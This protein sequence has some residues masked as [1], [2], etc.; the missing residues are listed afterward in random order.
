MYNS[1]TVPFIIHCSMTWVDGKSME[2]FLPTLPMTKSPVSLSGQVIFPLVFQVVFYVW[3]YSKMASWDVMSLPSF[4]SDLSIVLYFSTFFIIS[5]N[6][7]LST[8]LCKWF[9]L[10]ALASCP[11]NGM[12]WASS[13]PMSVFLRVQFSNPGMNILCR[14]CLS[15][16]N[17]VFLDMFP[18]KFC[19]IILFILLELLIIL[20][21]Y[22]PFFHW[23]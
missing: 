14:Y 10:E 12:C 2:Y 13:L 23:Q 7:F 11:E 20:A 3:A 8:S 9:P 22:R 15:N 4:P 17:F 18:P 5:P 19:T 16:I 1:Y 21:F 6:R